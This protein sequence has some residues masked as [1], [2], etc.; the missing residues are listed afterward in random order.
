MIQSL[1]FVKGL[2]QFIF[3]GETDVGV[4]LQRK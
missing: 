3:Q 1:F 2:K 4:Y